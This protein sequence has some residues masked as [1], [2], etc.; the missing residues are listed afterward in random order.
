VVGQRIFISPRARRLAE[1]YGVPLTTLQA[2]G[3]EGAIV[4]RDVRAY[5]QAEAEPRISPVA[6]RVAQEAGVDWHSLVGTSPGGRIMRQ[7][8]STARKALGQGGPA[9]GEVLESIPVAGV[10]AVIAQRM[11][12]SSATTANVTLNS[13]AD[14]TAL[15]ALRRQLAKDGVEVSYNALLIQI[16]GRALGDHPRLNASLRGDTIQVWRRIHVGLAVDTDRGLLVPVVRDVAGKGLIQLESGI[17]SVVERARAGK[18]APEELSGATF[19]LTNLGMYS[20]DSF[21][22]IINLPEC[23]ILGV[24]RIKKKLAVAQDL[25]DLEDLSGLAVRE[26]M[27]LSLSFDHRLVDGGPA[28]RFVQ[29]VVQLIEHPHLLLA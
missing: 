28:A 18:C 8:V 17:G 4:E 7:D 13:E 27:W 20:I 21:T 9:E 1:E 10:R 25:T 15:V 2:T 29:R 19:T 24:G 12:Q 14:A 22:P 3:P 23:A 5:L 16:L 6:R 11:A 26:T